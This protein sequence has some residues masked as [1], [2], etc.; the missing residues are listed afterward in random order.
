MTV[1]ID[2]SITALH[3]GQAAAAG[4]VLA[5]SLVDDPA[6]A[7]LVPD[8]Q[9]RLV[10]L[11]STLT[12][13]VRDAT[14]FGTAYGAV[15]DGRVVGAAVWLPPGAF[16]MD[17]RR[18]LRAAPAATLP[19]L[20]RARGSLSGVMRFGGNVERAFPAEPVWYLEVLGVAP[21]GQGRGV[22]TRLLQPVLERADRDGLPCYLE[23]AKQAN[24]G[25]YERL[26]F[27]AERDGARLAPGGPTHWTM[28]RP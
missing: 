13:A 16:P 1:H 24:V 28:R 22:G 15:E 8:R 26:G 4:A 10:A 14:T 3:P 2:M 12:A 25:F 18:K 7:H 5:A 17:W 20:L 6:W 21:E 19:L 9:A 27:R 11:R 23:T